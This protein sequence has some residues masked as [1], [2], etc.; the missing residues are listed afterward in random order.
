KF[1][2]GTQQTNIQGNSAQGDP[3]G[4]SAPMN[5]SDDQLPF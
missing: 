4:N 1:G 3:F 2:G 5:I